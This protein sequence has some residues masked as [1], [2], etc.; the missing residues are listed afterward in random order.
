VSLCTADTTMPRNDLRGAI[1][2]T[3]A[4]GM[5]VKGEYCSLCSCQR[6]VNRASQSSMDDHAEAI[7]ELQHYVGMLIS[8]VNRLSR[9]V[10]GDDKHRIGDL[11]GL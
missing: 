7:E 5:H 2:A 3:D 8:Q 9:Q 1:N 6:R 4:P 10:E 11:Y